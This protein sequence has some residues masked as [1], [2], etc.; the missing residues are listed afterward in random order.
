MPAVRADRQQIAGT[1]PAATWSLDFTGIHHVCI[2]ELKWLWLCAV[3]TNDY[4]SVT[5]QIEKLMHEL[6]AEARTAPAIAAAKRPSISQQAASSAST[7]PAAAAAAASSSSSTAAASAAMLRPFA[8]VDEV[9]SS[10]PAEEAGVLVGDQLVAF[11]DVTG[12]TQNTLPAVAAALQVMQH[13]LSSPHNLAYCIISSLHMAAVLI[14]TLSEKVHLK[15]VV[16]GS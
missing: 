4:K 13:S 8:V 3:L 9:S 11:A 7:P 6:H 16:A 10:S 14:L 5:N 2:S 12:Q 1:I 15:L